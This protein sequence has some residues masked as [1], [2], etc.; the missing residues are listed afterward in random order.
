MVVTLAEQSR[1]TPAPAGDVRPGVHRATAGSAGTGRPTA[2]G[3][4]PGELA[5]AL[6]DG[7]LLVA[8]QP[9]VALGDGA[10]CGS[11]A[12]VR[13]QHP[14]LGLLLPGRFLPLVGGAVS[15]AALDLHVLTAVCRDLAD[16]PGALSVSVNVSRA[17]L[18]SPGFARAVLR[19]LREH[20]VAGERVMLE[21]SEQLTLDDL[22]AVGD[23][24]RLL[25]RHDVRL[26]L[27]DLGAGATTLQHVRRLRPAWVKVDRRLVTRVDED[28]RRLAVVR[29]AVDLAAAVGAGVTAEG[30]ER[31]EEARALLAAGCRRGQGW[32]FGRPLLRRAPGAATADGDAAAAG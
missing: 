5:T 2:P 21:L 14:R 15:A 8:Q 24:L 28:A 12:L 13:W 29:R 11:E 30:V 7:R 9:V 25:R 23:E 32:L 3:P 20:E 17:A 19:V 4:R 16:D 10:V 18:L 6:R 31:P 22:D 1:L 26:V 27:D